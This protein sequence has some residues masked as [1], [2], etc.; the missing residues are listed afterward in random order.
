[1]LQFIVTRDLCQWGVMDPDYQGEIWVILQNEGKNDLF[2]NKHDRIAQLLILLCVIGKV[3]KGEPPTL[4]TVRVDG[5][6]GSTKEIHVTGAGIWV[7]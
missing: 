2:I 4:L 7:K 1:M 5:G 6:F 3:Q